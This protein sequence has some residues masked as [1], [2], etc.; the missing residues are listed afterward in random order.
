MCE[1]IIWNNGEEGRE[2]KAAECVKEAI[3]SN[4][5]YSLSLN[6]FDLPNLS[7]RGRRIWSF[8]YIHAYVH[9]YSPTLPWFSTFPR[10]YDQVG[11]DIALQDF[12]SSTEGW[13]AGLLCNSTWL[14]FSITIIFSPTRAGEDILSHMLH[15]YFFTFFFRS[16]HHLFEIFLLQNCGQSS[17]QSLIFL[18]GIWDSWKTLTLAFGQ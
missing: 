7:Q 14:T 15:Y 16:K 2:S 12:Y 3:I 18:F 4:T 5:L 10:N 13:V 8:T 6:T 1:S 11:E 17:H 9:T